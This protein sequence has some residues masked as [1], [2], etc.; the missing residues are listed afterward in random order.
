MSRRGE[1]E[2]EMEY[3]GVLERASDEGS[4]GVDD[5]FGLDGEVDGTRGFGFKF[6]L[7]VSVSRSRPQAHCRSVSREQV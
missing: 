3:G 6:P 7:T 1:G 2:A 5:S 4:V